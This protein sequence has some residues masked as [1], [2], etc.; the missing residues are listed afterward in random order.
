MRSPDATRRGASLIELAVT[1][2][3][4]A[5][6]A[7]ILLPHLLSA[8]ES[9]RDAGSLG[10]LRTHGM[11]FSQYISSH[12]ESFPYFTSPDGPVQIPYDGHSYETIYFLAHVRWPLVFADEFYEGIAP[13][14]TQN[15]P[16]SFSTAGYS[17]YYSASMLADPSFWDLTTRTGPDQWRATRRDEVLHPSRKALL[18]ESRSD[19][20]GGPPYF[21]IP[22][23]TR[24]LLATVDGAAQARRAVQL[25]EPVRSGEG[26][27][28]GT[29]HRFG[30]FGMHTVH[31]VRG[32]DIR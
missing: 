1:V 2:A 4:V 31:G 20:R 6:L 18:V 21:N 11:A 27:Y 32:M 24:V 22:S 17:Y 7:T 16:G 14:K 3:V 15:R 9:A 19:V 25:S 8:R 28:E 26:P 10:N 13:H 12:N 29:V 30:I 23:S 5:V